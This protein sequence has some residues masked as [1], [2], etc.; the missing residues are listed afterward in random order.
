MGHGAAAHRAA[1]GDVTVGLAINRSLYQHLRLQVELEIAAHFDRL[2][3]ATDKE[4]IAVVVVD[5]EHPAVLN[6]FLLLDALTAADV[7]RQAF[8]HNQLIAARFDQDVAVGLLGGHH[9]F[10]IDAGLGWGVGVVGEAHTIGAPAI[11]GQTDAGRLETP[12]TDLACHE[13]GPSQPLEL[14]RLQGAVV[15]LFFDGLLAGFLLALT[16]T[17][18]PKSAFNRQCLLEL[19]AADALIDGSDGF[20]PQ[21]FLFGQ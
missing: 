16:A 8:F 9:I 5:A 10:S 4:T 1:G 14:G 2:E 17:R 18:H 15:V 20:G 19:N 13:L 21:L 12:P 6:F 7:D 3:I 11:R